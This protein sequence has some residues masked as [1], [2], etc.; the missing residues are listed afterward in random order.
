MK[1]LVYIGTA[2]AF[3]LVAV[4]LVPLFLPMSLE[5]WGIIGIFLVAAVAG[6]LL[7]PWVAIRPVR[8][9]VRQV[10]AIPL[11]DL[12]A[13]LLGAFVGLLFAALLYLP[14]SAL[15]DPIRD[16]APITVAVL[17]A[18]SMGAIFWSQ[19][20]AADR[21]LPARLRTNPRPG[22]D[23]ATAVGQRAIL[24]T[25]A[26]IDGRIA[27]I[28]ETGFLRGSVIVPAFVLRELQYIADAPEANRRNRGRRGL[29]VLARMQKDGHVQVEFTDQDFDDLTEVDDKLVA[30]ARACG[31]P[32]V[33][34]DFNLN[35]VATL[36]GIVILNVNSL[37]NAVKAVVLPG[38]EM[39][40]QI[41][42]EGKEAGQGVGFLD[43]GTMVVVENG[44][45]HLE[46][47]VPVVVTRVLTTVA[48]RMIFATLRGS[49]LRT[50]RQAG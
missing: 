18:I 28:A 42:Q 4:V 39:E 43:D 29:D 1:R 45:R 46:S 24:D 33:T 26:I 35:R 31:A 14:L 19:Q 6:A 7:T 32:V 30:L 23:P 2:L 22:A 11:R 12:L 5:L 9:F 27:D 15:P 25:S 8:W 10:T 21:I 17:L 47:R 44:R 49:E 34:N 16:Y 41:I 50:E 36:Q 48:G 40:I 13:T 38:E 20:H 3:G 37:A